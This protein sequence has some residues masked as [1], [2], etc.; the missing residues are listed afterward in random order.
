[1]Q[2][3]RRHDPLSEVASPLWRAAP[4]F[5]ARRSGR[6]RPFCRPARSSTR[7]P[8]P[9]ETRW[10]HLCSPSQSGQSF[11]SMMTG[12]RSWIAD[13]VWFASVV[14]A[15]TVRN[16]SPSGDRHSSHISPKAT[17][18]PSTRGLRRTVLCLRGLPATR[19]KRRR[20][21]GSGAS[22]TAPGTSQT[23]PPSPSGR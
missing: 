23:W 16:V 8:P 6:C 13:R 14:M 2:T 9:V 21:R 4:A 22:R 11:S 20:L 7:P 18:S 19:N 15:A 5:S 12:I 10:R 3:R 17:E 1:L